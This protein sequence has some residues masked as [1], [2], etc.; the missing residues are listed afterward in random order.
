MQTETAV[1]TLLAEIGLK[2]VRAALAAGTFAGM[3]L[4]QEKVEE[5]SLSPDTAAAA[6][7]ATLDERTGRGASLVW[8]KLTEGQREMVLAAAREAGLEDTE[9]LEMDLGMY[10]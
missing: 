9:D 7:A 3:I 6:E 5:P 4:E 1:Q 8:G 10:L 2:K